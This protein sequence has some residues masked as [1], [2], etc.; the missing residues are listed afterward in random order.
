VCDQVVGLEK[1]VQVPEGLTGWRTTSRIASILIAVTS[2]VVRIG[3]DVKFLVVGTTSNETVG[4]LDG[5]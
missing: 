2:L 5:Q 4:G 1:R 3:D